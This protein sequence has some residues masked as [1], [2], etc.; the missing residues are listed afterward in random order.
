MT[1]MASAII[2]SAVIGGV[3][4]NKASKAAAAAADR[5]TEA[6]AYQGEI[7]KEQW[8]DY[9]STYQPLEHQMADEAKN[10]DSDE[11]YNKAAGAAQ[12]TVSTQMD[13]ARERL[14]RTPGFDPSSAAAQAANSDLVLKGAAIGAAAQNTAR[15]NVKNMAYAKK[16]DAIALGKGLVSNAASGVAAAS[17]GANSIAA[18]QAAQAGA[19]AQGAGAMVGG[20]INGLSK[21][22]W[23]TNTS[24][25]SAAF[26][27]YNKGVS[28]A[29]GLTPAELAGAFG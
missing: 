9:K 5:A 12:A 28:Q 13:L 20:V 27:N 2:G 26:D 4:A 16:Q 1:G 10:A 25:G 3:A 17:A 11:A 18:N 24:S 29:T 21:V 19:T 22:N 23:G 7:A 14:R 15:E 6:N 8:A